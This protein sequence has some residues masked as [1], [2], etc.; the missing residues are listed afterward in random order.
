MIRFMH[1]KGNKYIDHMINHAAYTLA[2]SIPPD[3]GGILLELA[4]SQCGSSER[5][6]AIQALRFY[7]KDE[8]KEKLLPLLKDESKWV[9]II[10]ARLLAWA[11]YNDGLDILITS[12]NNG[13]Y[14]SAAALR[15]FPDNKKAV[16]TLKK[17]LKS[18]DKK[19]L[20]YLKLH[21]EKLPTAK[22]GTDQ[23]PRIAVERKG[24][25][26]KKILVGC[27]LVLLGIACMIIRQI[28]LN[29]FAALAYMSP[30]PNEAQTK[31]QFPVFWY[32]C[33]ITGYNMFEHAEEMGG[34]DAGIII[35]SVF[36][37][38]YAWIVIGQILII[39]GIY[40]FFDAGFSASKP[41][42]IKVLR[43]VVILL[44]LLFIIHGI[45][46]I[47]IELWRFGLKSEIVPFE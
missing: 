7:Y 20:K 34:W 12:A 44:I 4:T 16:E 39:I 36:H 11:G 10:T 8:M 19:F 45:W 26:G 38:L 42:L 40:L 15:Y 9:P 43:I 37:H 2:E 23:F 25:K 29:E 3:A 1:S 46:G 14:A 5:T 24:G 6:A 28:A 33:S 47:G 41:K 35:Q 18:K 31:E 13:D 17:A 32:A 30:S 21:L 27:A 22:S